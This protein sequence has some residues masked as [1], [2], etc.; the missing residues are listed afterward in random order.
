MQPPEFLSLL[1]SA[2][3]VAHWKSWMAT[4]QVQEIFQQNEPCFVDLEQNPCKGGACTP[5]PG[6]PSLLT[7]GVLVKC[8]PHNVR[9][10]HPLE[11]AQIQG[12]NM[13]ERLGLPVC[14]FRHLFA[15]MSARDLKHLMGNGMALSVEAAW[16]LYVLSNVVRREPMTLARLNSRPEEDD[17]ED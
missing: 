13:W 17:L 11:L 12:F 4:S 15:R 5:G 8:T 9:C 14:R 2:S 3:S 1:Q 10:V 6:I 7:H 16:M